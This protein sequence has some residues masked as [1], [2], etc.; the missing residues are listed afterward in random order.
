MLK[1]KRERYEEW[2]RREDQLRE[3]WRQAIQT[4]QEIRD[5]DAILAAFAATEAYQ[6]A[7]ADELPFIQETDEEKAHRE[8]QQQELPIWRKARELRLNFLRERLQVQQDAHALATAKRAKED[9]AADEMITQVL[10][11]AEKQERDREA[12]RGRERLRRQRTREQTA[13]RERAH[14][15]RQRRAAR[16]APEPKPDYD[17]LREQEGFRRQQTQN[18]WQAR[19][20]RDQR[21]QDDD[22]RHHDWWAR[23][24]GWA[25]CP[26]CG[27]MKPCLF[28]CPGCG[29]KAC[30]ACLARIRLGYQ[31]A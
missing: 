1:A 21:Q 17:A 22:C 12:A 2:Q 14:H 18:A 28:H 29:K 6:N 23:V 5:V 10:A 13:E 27:F 4:Q 26:Q 9:Q 15:E 31:R 25:A 30:S 11:E 3:L 19:A 7:W 8:R 20:A 24:H 16:A